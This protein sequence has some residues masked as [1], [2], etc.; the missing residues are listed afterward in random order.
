MLDRWV[1]QYKR[2]GNDAFPNSLGPGE[3]KDEQRTFELEALVGRL[4]LENQILKAALKK[5]GWDAEPESG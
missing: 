1:D 4:T 5:G 2:L 3:L